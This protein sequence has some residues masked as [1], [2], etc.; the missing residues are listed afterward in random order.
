MK[1]T[2]N[3][4]ALCFTMSVFPASVSSAELIVNW[5]DMINIHNAK[6]IEKVAEETG[7]SIKYVRPLQK[8]FD[9]VSVDID[10]KEA[11]SILL[12]TGYFKFVEENAIITN[13]Q[14]QRTL[15]DKTSFKVNKKNSDVGTQSLVANKFSD[16]LYLKQSSFDE[17]EKT[18]MGLSNIEKARDYAIKHKVIDHKVRVAV[19][20]TGKWPHEDINWSSV[21]EAS[22][23]SGLSNG[24]GCLTADNLNTGKD[25]TCSENN[26]FELF[27]SN[28]S[29]DKS[30]Y[31]NSNNVFEVFV[32]GHGL[33]VASQIAATSNNG[34]GMVGIVPQN[35]VEIVPVRVLGKSSSGNSVSDGVF[36]AIG[37]YDNYGLKEGDKGYVRPIS[38]PVEF[39]N[40]SLGGKADLSCESN[41]YMKSAIEEAYSKNIS[42]VIAAG[43][44]ST[45]T[46]YVYPANCEEAF[47]VSSNQISGEISKFS[48]YGTYSDLSM[49]GEE[50]TVAEISSNYYG[51]SA[52]CGVAADYSDCYSFS[53]GTSMATPN[54]VGVL[55][56]MKMVHPDLSAKELEAMLLNTA[57]P[58]E[59]KGDGTASRASKVGYGAGVVNAYNALINDP[60]EID[61]VKLEHRYGNTNAAFQDAYVVEIKKVI[62]SVCSMYNVQ[63]GSLQ[64]E[65]E[66][67]SYKLMQTNE[68]GSIGSVSFTNIFD[69]TVPKTIV[70]RSVYLRAAVQSCKNGVCGSLV[71]LDFSQTQ[72]PTI[73]KV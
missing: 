25:A 54:V 45:D 57:V 31:K 52:N 38:E 9:L 53:R 58:F 46:K 34:L 10:S 23:L 26:T 13:P 7:V 22:F 8:T 42:V 17:Q 47:T 63:F 32:N 71:E 66:G 72:K 70:D 64:H 29:L 28:D 61:N 21:D 62:P 1:I 56:L 65:T 50:I 40:L 30:W 73:C 15:I 39:I 24:S 2:K 27:P 16:P 6:M 48:N 67:V 4:L 35:S 36:W 5:S 55:A 14:V 19:L 44:E 37:S 18:R 51:S 3:T 68:L 12:K 33:A 59:Q 43:N 49:I 20:D 60:L 41:S 11:I 69:L